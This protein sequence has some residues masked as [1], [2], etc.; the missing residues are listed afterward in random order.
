M[1]RNF[2]S[3]LFSIV[4]TTAVVLPSHPAVADDQTFSAKKG[5]ITLPEQQRSFMKELAQLS[6]KYPGLAQHGRI[7]EDMCEINPRCVYVASWSACCCDEGGSMT[8][9]AWPPQ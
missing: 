8:C 2:Y 4:V 3:I 9:E 5:S 7:F 1:V 6:R